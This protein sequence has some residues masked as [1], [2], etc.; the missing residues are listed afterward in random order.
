MNKVLGRIFLTVVVSL[1]LSSR[2]SAT[3]PVI[4]VTSESG[5]VMYTDFGNGLDATYLVFQL[6]NSGGGVPDVWVTLDTS[7]SS[8]ISNVGSGI[9]ELKFKI[10]TGAHGTDPVAELGLA[11]GETK[12]V[13]FL[14]K[15]SSTTA[16]PQVLTVKVGSTSGASDYGTFPFAFTV[17]DTI[18][19]NANKVNTVLTIPNNPTIGLLGKITVTGCTGTVGAAKVLYFSPVSSHTWP[20]DAFEFV[21]SDIQIANYANSPYRDVALIPTADVLTTNNCYDEIFTFQIDSVGTANT[22]PANYISSGTQVKHTSNT[23]GS[24]SVTIPPPTCAGFSAVTISPSTVPD[25][26]DGSAY[27]QQLSASGGPAGTYTF[28]STTLPAW[29]NLSSS[30][31]LSGTPATSDVGSFSFTVTATDTPTSGSD[32]TCSGQITYN[33]T[34]DPAVV[35]NLVQV[36][37]L[38]NTAL[39]LMALALAGAAFLLIRRF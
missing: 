21:D 39:A 28:T 17:A 15:A 12:G 16:T 27:S 23:S 22:S 35:A 37:T 8:I 38:G 6:L 14:V 18:Q 20:A 10:S 3:V 11:N 25:A 36:P 9:H 26:T 24:F 2:A 33:F 29:L 7:A 5:S 1:A 4:S 30:G 32:P 13:F 34:V 19:A 31:L